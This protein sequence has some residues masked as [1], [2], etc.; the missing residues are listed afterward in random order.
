MALEVLGLFEDFAED[1]VAFLAI[2]AKME[3]IIRAA[4]C[5]GGRTV[6]DAASGV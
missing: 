2:D 1:F 6:S 3:E 5:G 4:K